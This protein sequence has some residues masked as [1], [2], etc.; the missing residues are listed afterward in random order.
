MLLLSRELL[1]YILNR[2][3]GVDGYYTAFALAFYY[4]T[5]PKHA[6]DPPS[7]TVLAQFDFS[8]PWATP[9]GNN[10]VER[11]GPITTT[12]TTTGKASYWRIIGLHGGTWKNVVH[13]SIGLVGSDAD[14]KVN[15]L[16]W[17]IGDPLK[18]DVIQIFPLK[19]SY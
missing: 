15:T 12:V 8:S 7:S 16:E 11:T 4:G 5:D 14:I 6:A 3:S 2:I 9:R 1:P 18:L 17:V 13:G 10:R 19:L